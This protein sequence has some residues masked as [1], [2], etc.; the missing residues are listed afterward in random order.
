MQTDRP[1]ENTDSQRFWELKGMIV[2][3][4]VLLNTKD[5]VQQDAGLTVLEV[6]TRLADEYGGEAL[7]REERAAA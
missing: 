4:H 6:A 2:A 1:N 5:C 7:E 3:A